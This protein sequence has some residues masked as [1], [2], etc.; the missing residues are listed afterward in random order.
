MTTLRVGIANYEAIKARSMRVVLGK[1]NPS[2]ADPTVWFVSTETF[3]RVFSTR[4]RE[5]LRIIAE[6]A[7]GSLDELADAVGLTPSDLSPILAE[8]DGFGLVHAGYGPNR[9]IEP[10]VLYDRVELV[11]LLADRP[12]TAITN[13][14]KDI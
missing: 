3:A 13:D 8:W 10:R 7:P 5:I 14:H 12:N 9:K 2:A 11:L 6:E 1:E 4:N